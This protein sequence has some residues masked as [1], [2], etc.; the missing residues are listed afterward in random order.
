MKILR[1]AYVYAS[2]FV[3]WLCEKL[4]RGVVRLAIFFC[5]IKMGWLASLMVSLA[6]IINRRRDVAKCIVGGLGFVLVAGAV[7]FGVLLFLVAVFII[8]VLKSFFPWFSSL[9]EEVSDEHIS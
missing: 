5:R 3:L 6:Q 2:I 9:G 8:L 1:L 7:Y 4:F